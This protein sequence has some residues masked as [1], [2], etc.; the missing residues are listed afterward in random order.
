MK[1]LIKVCILAFMLISISNSRAE[2]L[3]GNEEKFIFEQHYAENF[4]QQSITFTLSCGIQ[5]VMI[6]DDD[7]WQPSAFEVI[8]NIQSLDEFY[9]Q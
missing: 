8:S 6:W 7:Y 1:N 9:C 4:K 5:G 3:T 2:N